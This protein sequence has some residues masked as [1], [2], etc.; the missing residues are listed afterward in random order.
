MVR[1]AWSRSELVGLPHE[2]LIDLVLQLQRDSAAQDNGTEPRVEDL[3]GVPPRTVTAD[4]L[5][6]RLTLL[7]AVA[8]ALNEPTDETTIIDRVLE[9]VYAM[10]DLRRA[11]VLL[12]NKDN[13]LEVARLITADQPIH[14]PE[15][16]VISLAVRRGLSGWVWRYQRSIVVPDVAREPHWEEVWQ[17]R[18]PG[19]ACAVP[20]RQG[21]SV[22]GV[23]VMYHAAPNAFARADLLWLEGI[24]ALINVALA[25]A[26]QRMDERMR[27]DHLLALLGTANYV[28]A[29]RSL[30]ELA[31]MVQTRSTQMFGVDYGLLFLAD[32]AATLRALSLRALSSLPTASQ[33]VQDA[34]QVQ[35]RAH[36]IALLAWRRNVPVVPQT[37]E[38]QPAPFA[39]IGLPLTH[40]GQ[41]IGALVLVYR[42]ARPLV[43]AARVW[44]M[45]TVFTSFL[46]ATCYN[47]QLVQQLRYR[48]DVLEA[49]VRERTRQL[50]HS[51]DTLRAV[52]DNDPSGILFLDNNEQITA[53]N[54]TFC[55][56]FVGQHPRVL[57]GLAYDHLWKQMVRTDLRVTRHRL[58]SATPPYATRQHASADG[59]GGVADVTRAIFR[60][61]WHSQQ[62]WYLVT[63]HAVYDD[64]TVTG[65]VERWENVSARDDL[66]SLLLWSDQTVVLTD[67]LQQTLH[68]AGRVL[69]TA[70]PAGQP[71]QAALPALAATL[72][73]LQQLETTVT[74]VQR[75]LTVPIAQWRT[76][77]LNAVLRVTVER[78]TAHV[79]AGDGHIILTLD[80]ALPAFLLDSDA[81]AA[82][83]TTFTHSLADCM[84]AGERLEIATRWL[85]FS[86][87]CRVTFR[88]VAPRASLE[89]LT[90]WFG[91]WRN[92]ARATP[93]AMVIAHQVVQRHAGEVTLQVEPLSDAPT[94][95]VALQ[96]ELPF[97]LDEIG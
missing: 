25:A 65:Y 97:V 49:E 23:L 68:E 87:A 90:A 31:Q 48:R 46:A 88:T 14:T 61:L 10:L 42:T 50:R 19:S 1:R 33:S 8:V 73:Q 45:L 29:E 96:V 44:S 89:Q 70:V 85:A 34:Q 36:D 78:S 18:Q 3:G 35:A 5:Q 93:P 91:D 74:A 9:T 84:A 54:S 11:L 83:F 17:I 12:W 27:R 22:R 32:D 30:D 20:L 92:A 38:Q 81:L 58:L 67:A 37:D 59:V 2:Q 47:V 56:W 76:A 72:A 51:R 69:A 52:F 21:R 15:P 64:Q 7:T 4:E 16:E 80:D 71:R 62:S 39:F 6:R 40:S 95:R 75:L 66:P 28:S 86:Y 53:S 43:L 94:Q 26:E 41:A 79:A 77:D 60:V 55:N 63:R 82:A 13:R 24:A 57:I